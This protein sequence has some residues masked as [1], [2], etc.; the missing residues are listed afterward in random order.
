MRW[1]LVRAGWVIALVA[2][3]WVAGRAQDRPEPQFVLNVEAPQGWTKVVCVRGCELVAERSSTTAK[4]MPEFIYGCGVS[5]TPE[6]PRLQPVREG[7]RCKGTALGWIVP[8]R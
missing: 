6:A 5:G 7:L 4:R 3:G 8:S 2:L 1:T